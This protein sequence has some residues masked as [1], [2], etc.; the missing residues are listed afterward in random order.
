MLQG[1][2]DGGDAGNV[3]GGGL[4]IVVAD[5]GDV[6]GDA[7]SGVVEGAD[8][9]HGGDVVEADDGGEG[10]G[11]PEDFLD[12]GI[13]DFGGVGVLFEADGESFADGE[14]EVAGDGDR[15]VP[16]GDG[17]GAEGLAAHVDDL[18]MTEGMEVA[19]GEAGAEVAIEDDV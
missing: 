6:F 7:E 5:D 18:A 3:I 10:G 16:A 15:G 11:F 14:V 1:L 13:A 17:V 12:A 8:D 9:A 19:E 4:D 2:A